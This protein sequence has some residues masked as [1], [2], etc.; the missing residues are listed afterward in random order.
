MIFEWEE[1]KKL[2]VCQTYRA[3]VP[4]GWLVN[5]V[6]KFM[7]AR[8]VAAGQSESMAFVADPGHKWE[9]DA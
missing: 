6:S 2:N 9:V 7:D 1:I 3:K 5:N 8:G 4:G